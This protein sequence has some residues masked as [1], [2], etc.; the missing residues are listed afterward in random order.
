MRKLVGRALVGMA[1]AVLAAALLAPSVSAS[2]IGDAEAAMMAAWEKAGGDTS[3]LGARK[4]DVYPAGDGFAL[5]FDGGKMFYTTDT[6]AK[7]V[8]GPI[9]DK[10]EALG[11]PVGSDLGFPTIN[12]VPGLAGPDSRVAT[13][14][15]SDKPVI[16]WTPDHGAFVVRGAM[17]AAWDKLGSS[18]G[19]LGAPAGDETYNGEVTSQK[20]SGG[21]IS[22]NRKT[23]EFAT[24]PAPLADQLKG[25][26]VAIDPAAAI[27]MAWRAAG[28]ASGPLGAKQGATYPI[29]GDAI[30]QNFAGGKVFFNPATGANAL[31]SDILAK[32]ESLGGPAGSDLG[33]PT[34]NES[35]GGIGP[36]S[37]I[38]TFAAADKPVIFWTP[39]HG[40]FVVRGAM[41]AAWDKLRGPSGK[42]GAPVG[43]QAVDGDVVSQQFTGGKISW[44]RAKNSFATE[45][46][47]LAPLLS[48]L[49]VSGQNQPS[50]AAMPTHGKKFAWQRWWLP[51]AIGVLVLILLSGLLTF[52]LR[53]RR[54]RRGAG[55]I[56]GAPAYEPERDV[57]V[58]YEAPADAH[59]GH[60][61]AGL[62]T[63]HFAVEEQPAPDADSV[64]RVSWSRGPEGPVAEEEDP[65]AV[66][67]DSI[68]I[69]A[70]AALSEGGY[71]GV[72]DEGVYEDAAYDDVAY[73]DTG[74]E[75]ADYEEPGYERAGHPD[76]AEDAELP[77]TVGPEAAEALA[78][79]AESR[80]GR[81]HAAADEEEPSEGGETAAAAPV[82]GGRPTIRMPLDDPY[83]VPDGYPI[84][85]SASFGLYYTPESPLYH[86]TLAEI[87]LASEE[88][89]QANGFV[90]AD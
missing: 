20:F 78:M 23:K 29:G 2:P 31:E 44:N 65:D 28:G 51:A 88:V 46:S 21:E 85:A 24:N 35:D 68:P 39:D 4:G 17:N 18:G 14:S 37:R 26:Q 9:M 87:W 82:V 32:Y 58:G 56:A 76:A 45:P 79:S 63:D 89:A 57:H 43:D 12:E 80:I 38:A 25:L 41:K 42:L 30:A 16:F 15:A 10:Y 67:T 71:P 70:V 81:H 50:T 34:A 54:A 90:K 69:V 13:F 60:D 53:R 40:A 77:E 3:P 62:A 11:G 19:V 66:D 7:F 1:T 72:D 49:Q 74:Y 59:W 73:E 48:G 52:G 36:S 22:W 33:F 75:Q 6:G 47:N 61:D 86:D 84:K 83:Q 27:N 5:D 8:Y 55:D 64:G